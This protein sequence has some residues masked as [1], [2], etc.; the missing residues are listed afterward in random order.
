[1]DNIPPTPRDHSA[2]ASVLPIDFFVDE[3]LHHMGTQEGVDM[4]VLGKEVCELT[5]F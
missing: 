5:N 2:I 3:P 4:P 1:M